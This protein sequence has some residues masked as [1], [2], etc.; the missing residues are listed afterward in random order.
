MNRTEDIQN[1]VNQRV[2]RSFIT[3]GWDDK[4]K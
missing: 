3:S 4:P 1:H 2:F